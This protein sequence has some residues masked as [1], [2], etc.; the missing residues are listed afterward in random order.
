MIWFCLV[1]GDLAT[2]IGLN[3][4][5]TQYLDNVYLSSAQLT[6]IKSKLNTST[7]SAT[8]ASLNAQYQ[9]QINDITLTTDSSVLGNNDISKVISE[10]NYTLM[11]PYQTPT[12]NVPRIHRKTSGPGLRLNV[13]QT[14]LMLCQDQPARPTPAVL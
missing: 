3:T 10:W 7:N 1:D 11:F 12:K 13:H 9:N 2:V 8:V 14:I 4:T 5:E 6:K